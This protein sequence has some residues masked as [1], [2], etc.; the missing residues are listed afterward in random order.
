MSKSCVR[1]FGNRSWIKC[2]L[3]FETDTRKN[4]L[5]ADIFT[6]SSL[7]STHHYRLIGWACANIIWKTTNS[8]RPSTTS[9]WC[10]CTTY[11]HKD[12]DSSSSSNLWFPISRR[13]LQMSTIPWENLT[14]RLT[15][16]CYSRCRFLLG[17]Q[18]SALYQ[19]WKFSTSP[20]MTWIQ[21]AWTHKIKTFFALFDILRTLPVVQYLDD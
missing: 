10:D 21:F 6:S 19:N 14:S 4:T 7:S 2:V 15:W 3:P 8:C 5:R 13:W 16:Q 20:I 17:L 18:A 11:F 9:M 12:W 1:R